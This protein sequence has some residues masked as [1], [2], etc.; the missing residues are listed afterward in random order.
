MAIS[1]STAARLCTT[2]E[3]QLVD[4]SFPAKSRELTPSRLRQ[5]I[6]R[7][8][9]LRD[10][11]T[12][13]A[14][15]QRLEARGKAEPRR[16]RPAARN[17]NTL[18][19]AQLFE[20]VLERF[21]SRLDAGRADAGAPGSPG[22]AGRPGPARGPAASRA[23]AKKQAAKKAAGRKAAGRKAAGEKAAAKKAAAK[24]A[25]GRKAAG[26]AVAVGRAPAGGEA[27]PA[28]PG[29]PGAAALKGARQRPDA[30]QKAQPTNALAHSRASG[31]RA[32]RRRDTR[33]S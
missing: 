1:R 17:D 26:T 10:K 5:K 24:K 33:N 19:K 30:R 4:A 14:R 7:A 8:R 16:S 20:E 13:L 9:K 27:Q 21:Q 18:R 28:P 23:A 29:R 6:E 15:R 2:Q 31:S 3:M 12:D 32:Q 22:G 11:Y 25:A